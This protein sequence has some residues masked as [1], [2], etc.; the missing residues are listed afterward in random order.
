MKKKDNNDKMREPLEKA[1]KG[2][3]GSKKEENIGSK[4]VVDAEIEKHRNRQD[5]PGRDKTSKEE[6]SPKRG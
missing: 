4:Q 2:G 6:K 3:K 1:Q 5:Q